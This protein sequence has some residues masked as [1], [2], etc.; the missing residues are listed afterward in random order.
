[1]RRSALVVL[2]VCALVLLTSCASI[3]NPENERS[4][5]VIGSILLDFPDGLFDLPPRQIYSG[6]LITLRNKTQDGTFELKANERGYFF[7]LSNGSDEYSL[8][9]FRYSFTGSE[10][11]SYTIDQTIAGSFRAAPGQVSYLGQ[12]VYRFSAPNKTEQKLYAKT[13]STWNYKIEPVRNDKSDE[14]IKSLRA[15]DDHMPWLA[16]T[17]ALIEFSRN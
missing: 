12:L 11:N 4:S 5:L 1:M 17:V 16:R 13:A 10:R 7:F 9:R 3:P 15:Q 14:M 8:A 2:G 6:I